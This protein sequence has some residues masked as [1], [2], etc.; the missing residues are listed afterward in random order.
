[1][2][3]LPR[4]KRYDTLVFGIFTLFLYA[5]VVPIQYQFEPFLLRVAAITFLLFWY[6]SF[7]LLC[8]QRFS[9]LS[10]HRVF[11]SIFY[12]LIWVCVVVVFEGLVGPALG[13]DNGPRM[14]VGI[15]V[16]ILTMAGAAIIEKQWMRELSHRRMT[17][18]IHLLALKYYAT[19]QPKISNLELLPTSQK[20][21]SHLRLASFWIAYVPASR[22]GPGCCR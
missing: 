19:T 9:K 14:I 22:A 10:V 12:F 5:F 17:L 2:N 18:A 1:M 20:L 3:I 11:V 4:L 15:L 7:L 6:V 13:L 21:A 16:G 8:T